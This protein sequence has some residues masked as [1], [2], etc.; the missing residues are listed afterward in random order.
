M[1]KFLAKLLF[2]LSCVLAYGAQAA[3]ITSTSALVFDSDT[4]DFGAKYGI[5]AYQQSF[6]ASYTFSYGGMF[7]LSGAVI[8]IA[9]KNVSGLNIT[10]FTLSGNGQTYTGTGSSSGGVTIYTLNASSLAAGN[11]TLTVSGAVTGTTGGSFGGNL[12]ISAV[13]EASSLAMMLAG[14]G[15]VAGFALRRQRKLPEAPS[16]PS[17]MPA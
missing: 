16:Q 15:L 12:N 7:D 2:I 6:E 5:S 14:L 8:S 4:S 11:Y 17:L 10:S 1:Q 3:P 13:P 9:L